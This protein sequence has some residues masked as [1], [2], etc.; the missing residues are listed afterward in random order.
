M[1]SEYVSKRAKE[2]REEKMKKAAEARDNF[3]AMLEA[4]SLTSHSTYRDAETA[5]K[6]DARWQQ[7]ERSGREEE[8]RYFLQRLSDAEREV[9]E[10]G[11]AEAQSKKKAYKEELEQLKAA[12]AELGVSKDSHW[13]E[14]EPKL[15]EKFSGKMVSE[16]EQ[17]D[18]FYEMVSA[19]RKTEERQRAQRL[20]ELRSGM[21][22]LMDRFVCEGKLAPGVKWQ[23]VEP[24]ARSE[25]I[26]TRIEKE[27]GLRVGQLF[28]DYVDRMCDHARMEEKYLRELMATGE[29]QWTA[30]TTLEEV[31]AGMEKIKQQCEQTK[32]EAGEKMEVEEKEEKKEE[33]EE[34]KEEKEEKKEEKPK[35]EEKEKKEESA[36]APKEAETQ[37]SEEEKKKAEAEAKRRKALEYSI[38]WLRLFAKRPAIIRWIYERE[39]RRVDNG[40]IIER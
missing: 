33:K 37:Q 4:S 18:V 2:E 23:E 30:T 5:L 36:E 12:L 35:E 27:P 24:A 39:H 22:D 7:L 40:E 28:N 17:K 9:G 38:T 1:F 14:T 31:N 13:S 21:F 8:L 11:A 26:V 25:E 20:A 32:E 34:K 10:L 16:S 3:R 15:R 19:A 6:E 29:L